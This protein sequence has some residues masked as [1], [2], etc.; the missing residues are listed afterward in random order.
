[1]TNV[2][3]PTKGG[4]YLPMELF[5]DNVRHCISVGVRRE[6]EITRLFLVQFNKFRNFECFVM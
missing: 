5:R 1:M 6:G 3:K 4:P 2:G